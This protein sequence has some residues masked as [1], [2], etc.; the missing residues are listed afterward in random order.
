MKMR[1]GP[2]TPALGR[3]EACKLALLLAWG[4]TGPGALAQSRL[5]WRVWTAAAGL[6]ETYVRRIAMGADGR[7]W[8]RHGAVDAISVLDGYEVAQIPAPPVRDLQLSRIQRVYADSAAVAWTVEESTLQRYQNGRWTVEPSPHGLPMLMALPVHAGVL[9]LF[10]DRL[11][12]YRP[13]S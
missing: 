10:P 11:A 8:V 7:L 6:K 1:N 3:V 5:D 4:F 13:D 9:V 12:V 2:S